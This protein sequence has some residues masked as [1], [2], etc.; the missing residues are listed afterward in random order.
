L[1]LSRRIWGH[2]KERTRNHFLT[3]LLVIVP[4]ALTYYVVSKIVVFMDRIL[5]FVPKKFLPDTYLPF[6]IPGLGVIVT[7]IIIQAVGLLSANLLGRRVVKTY[8]IILEKIP[9]VR[10][11]YV[12]VKQLLEQILSSRADRF[13]QVVLIEYPRRGIYSIGL[14]TGECRGEVQGKVPKK[15]LNIFIP[16]TPNPTSGYYL[17]IPEEDVIPL[18]I[19]VEQA[20]KL[21]ISAGM[22]WH[23]ESTGDLPAAGPQPS[24]VRV[25]GP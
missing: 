24:S 12:A 4:L 21:I 2:I 7:L 3:G 9:L 22:V 11:I 5:A 25:S 13:R 19:T 8:E 10:G 17:V 1:S 14:V 16:T 20:F 18:S 23:E 6:H 15:V